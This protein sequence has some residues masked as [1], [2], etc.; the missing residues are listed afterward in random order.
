M[1]PD[2]QAAKAMAASAI[3]IATLNGSKRVPDSLGRRNTAI[4][5]LAIASLP[6]EDFRWFTRIGRQAQASSLRGQ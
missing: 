5:F 6:C 3:T 2:A 1:R 4:E